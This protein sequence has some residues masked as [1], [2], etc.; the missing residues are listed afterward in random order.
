VTVGVIS[1]IVGVFVASQPAK[2]GRQTRERTAELRRES[3]EQRL[4]AA[5]KRDAEA[6][7]WEKNC[8]ETDFDVLNERNQG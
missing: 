2:S 3:R 7:E 6:Y 4:A 5:E 8:P 1:S